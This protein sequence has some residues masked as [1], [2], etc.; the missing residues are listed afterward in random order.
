MSNAGIVDH[1]LRICPYEIKEVAPNLG[2][3]RLVQQR[4]LARTRHRI[5]RRIQQVG[6][7]SVY[8]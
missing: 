8:T 1:Q 2:K 3:N 7:N 4:H 6:A 5:A